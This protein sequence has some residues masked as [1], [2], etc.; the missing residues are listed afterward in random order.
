MNSISSSQKPRTRGSGSLFSPILKIIFA[1]AFFVPNYAT[2]I[3][4]PY[5]NMPKTDFNWRGSD[6]FRLG[7]PGFAFSPIKGERWGWKLSVLASICEGEG[8]NAGSS[9]RYTYHH[10]ERAGQWMQVRKAWNISIKND[11]RLYS[12]LPTQSHV[13][14][15]SPS[16]PVSRVPMA[17]SSGHRCWPR[18]ENRSRATRRWRRTTNQA[19]S[20]S[21]CNSTC[22]HC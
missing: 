21:H 6:F 22:H 4:Y 16:W 15:V 19:S 2:F 13:H 7:L 12:S 18:E 9:H 5:P 10:E 11:C 3:V 17:S 1:C 8:H 14:A 20:S